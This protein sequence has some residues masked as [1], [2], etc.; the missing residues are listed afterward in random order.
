MHVYMYEIHQSHFLITIMM[1]GLTC[2]ITNQ[3][4]IP[5]YDARTFSQYAQ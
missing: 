5:I 3:Q 4:R 1:G 2:V